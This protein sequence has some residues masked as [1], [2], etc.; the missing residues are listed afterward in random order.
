M[1]KYK[2][3]YGTFEKKFDITNLV[4]KKCMKKIYISRIEDNI[5]N[6][7]DAFIK[8]ELIINNQYKFE[9]NEQMEIYIDEIKSAIYG[10]LNIQIDIL[11]KYITD[12]FI[13]QDK[14]KIFSDVV[15]NKEKYFYIEDSK[16]YEYV[17]LEDSIITIHEEKIILCNKIINKCK[18]FHSE[19]KFNFPLEYIEKSTHIHNFHL[20]DLNYLLYHG[21]RSKNI[22]LS[23]EKN[24]ND[25]LKFLYGHD[26]KILGESP[27]DLCIF[28]SDIS[29]YESRIV[30]NF[31]IIYSIVRR[32]YIENTDWV[33]YDIIDDKISI[34]KRIIQYKKFL[35]PISFCIPPEKISDIE[36][37]KKTKLM[38]NIIPMRGGYIYN[39]EEDY[40]NDY[41]TSFFGIT[42]RRNG[43]DSLRH[44]EILMNA[45]IPY[46]VDLD[47]FPDEVLSLY[48]KQLILQSNKLY[49]TIQDLNI[50]TFI[51]SPHFIQYKCL[52]KALQEY[53]RNHLTTTAMANYVLEKTNHSKIN[54]ILFLSYH[55]RP[56]YM[57]CLLLHGFKT[58]FGNNCIDHPR[59]PHL[60]KN[61]KNDYTLYGNGF[62]YSKLLDTIESSDED[63]YKLIENHYFDVIIY[64]QTVQNQQLVSQ[65][66][67]L[68]YDH[69]MKYYSPHEVIFINGEDHVNHY[70][71]QDFYDKIDIGHYCFLREFCFFNDF[72]Y[73]KKFKEYF[74]GIIHDDDMHFI[75]SM[76]TPNN[77]SYRNK[78][79]PLYQKYLMSKKDCHNQILEIG[80]EKNTSIYLWYHFFKKSIIYS[81]NDDILSNDRIIISKEI[82]KQEYDIIIINNNVSF[83][84]PN[85][86]KLLKKNG[87]MIIENYQ[88]KMFFHHYTLEDDCLIINQN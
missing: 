18:T 86:Y 10:S 46:F 25:D 32:N 11:H 12:I 41:Q 4:Y 61:F 58:L 35:L 28:D 72:F 67:T 2:F 60:Y 38:A 62:T 6:L 54:K 56:D 37:N 14:N 71:L 87:I 20:Y 1:D 74:K 55:I 59:I 27:I 70:H 82:F 69:I 29:F 76:I 50:K 40:Y 22:F 8:R 7:K 80:F 75:I 77:L 84:I 68:Y 66:Y 49:E 52:L 65:K 57:R 73:I 53:T 5:F 78:Y 13:P 44:Y 83:T 15:P 85:L 23:Y 79:I 45:C 39:K 26:N 31:C 42:H 24:L 64:G 30:C 33:L 21:I 48:P 19:N 3:Y 88:S 9:K 34:L 16:G 81:N 51:S 47:L 43:W 17:Y 36:L 63:I